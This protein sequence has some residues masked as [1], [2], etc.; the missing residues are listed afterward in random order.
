M[1]YIN[2]GNCK[3]NMNLA[4]ENKELLPVLLIDKPVEPFIS[5]F[6]ALIFHGHQ[7]IETI[8]QELVAR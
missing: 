8:G 6:F 3:T 4:E 2:P 7:D 5:T 1:F